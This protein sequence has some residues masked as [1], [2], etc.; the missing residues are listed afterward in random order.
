MC[1]RGSGIANPP[2]TWTLGAHALAAALDADAVFSASGLVRTL[3]A[4]AGA[5]S[6]ATV[7]L[8][9]AFIHPV[10]AELLALA[11]EGDKLSAEQG[12]QVETLLGKWQHRN[13]WRH[14]AVSLLGWAFGVAAL[15]LDGRAQA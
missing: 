15:V 11:D 12:E 2:Q 10:N 6:L 8:T 1:P 5:L 9:L 4:H 13:A 3:A 14:G 7:P